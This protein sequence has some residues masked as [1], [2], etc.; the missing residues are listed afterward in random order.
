MLSTL[1]SY[2]SIHHAVQTH[3][4]EYYLIYENQQ[5][6]GYFA[7]RY[8]DSVIHLSKCYLLADLRGKGLFNQILVSLENTYRDALEIRLF[9]NKHNESR[10]IYEKYGFKKGKSFEFDI[11]HGYIMD[12]YEMIKKNRK[13]DSYGNE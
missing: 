1:Q 3:D 5:A 10:F 6:L 7:Y 12:D 9:V 4:L 8:E 11:G 2:Q 13:S